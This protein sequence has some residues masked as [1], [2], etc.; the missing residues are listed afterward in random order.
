MAFANSLVPSEDVDVDFIASVS[1]VYQ[2]WC[3][4]GLICLGLYQ[5]LGKIKVSYTIVC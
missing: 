5:T 1:V 3:S 4:G 2:C